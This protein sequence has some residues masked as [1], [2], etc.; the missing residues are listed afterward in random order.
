MPSVPAPAAF[1]GLNKE[2]EMSGLISGAHVIQAAVFRLDF[3]FMLVGLTLVTNK[4]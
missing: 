1:E 2:D 4:A 3:G